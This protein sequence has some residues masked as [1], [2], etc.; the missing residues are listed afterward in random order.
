MSSKNK[1][2]LYVIKVRLKKMSLQDL[3]NYIGVFPNIKLSL[4]IYLNAHFRIF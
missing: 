4:Q 3:K 1:L 2:F